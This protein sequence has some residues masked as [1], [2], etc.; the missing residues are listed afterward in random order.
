MT[1]L[2]RRL[3]LG[4]GWRTP[5]AAVPDVLLALAF[6][7]AMTAERLLTAPELPA[8]LPGVVIAGSLAWWRRAPLTAYL[9]GTAALAVEAQTVLPGPLSP[10]ANLIGLYALGRYA[11]RARARCGPVV[12]LVGMAGYFGD[13]AV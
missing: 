4:R 6:L 1:A 8:L 7:L 3:A 5:G 12:V 10:Y 11:T 13:P 9:L 2:T